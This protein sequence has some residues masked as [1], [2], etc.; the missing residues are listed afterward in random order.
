MAHVVWVFTVS[1]I[2]EF[3]DTVSRFLVASVSVTRCPTQF[4]MILR[5]KDD[6]VTFLHVYHHATIYAIWWMNCKYLPGGEGDERVCV[7][8]DLS[9]YVGT[10]ATSQRR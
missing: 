8:C 2:Y 7:G 5:K 1:K 9:A 3:L 10:Q 4:I 6:Q